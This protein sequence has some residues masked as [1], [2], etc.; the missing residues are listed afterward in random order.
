MQPGSN[1]RSSKSPR[2]I[3]KL[4][5]ISCTSVRR[6][7]KRDSQLKVFRRKK[8][9]LLSD[10]DREKRVECCKT[11]LARRCLQTVDK[12]WFSDEK[13]FTM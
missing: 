7:A 11:L 12:V 6:I 13:T 4:T 2:E 3:Q 9:H 1:P 5:E 10:S 8:V